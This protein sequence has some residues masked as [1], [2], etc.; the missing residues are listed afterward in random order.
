MKAATYPQRNITILLVL[1]LA[2]SLLLAACKPNPGSLQ[3]T[4]TPGD[5]PALAGETPGPKGPTATPSDH[6]RLTADAI[7]LELAYEPTFFRIEASYEYGRPPVFVLLADGRVIYTEEGATYDEERV[8][9]AQLTPDE[10]SSLLQKV[11]DMGIDK[12]ESYTDFCKD[13]SNGQQECIA[14]AAYT[15]LRIRM[16]DDSLK[17]IKIYADFANDVQAFTSIRDYLSA[18]THPDAVAYVPTKAALFLSKDMGDTSVVAKEWPLDTALLQPPANDLNLQA[19][20]LEGKALNDYLA[21]GDRN[22]GDAFFKGDGQTVYRAYFVPWL[23]GA[24]Y[25]TQLA[26]DFPHQ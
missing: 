1:F 18:Y 24:D 3:I 2:A 17:E 7:L 16:P 5:P 14:D 12:L 20:V 26:T 10:V 13:S 4:P 22:V 23:P 11:S 21:S 8:M 25:S 9:I 15:I 6:G 19:I